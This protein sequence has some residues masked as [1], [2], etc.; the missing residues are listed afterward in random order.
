MTL[1]DFS[2]YVSFRCSLIP[3][4]LIQIG[5]GEAQ[6]LHVQ[7]H[8]Q[9]SKVGVNS[10]CFPHFVLQKWYSH[11]CCHHDYNNGDISISYCFN[12]GYVYGDKKEIKILEAFAIIPVWGALVRQRKLQTWPKTFSDWLQLRMRMVRIVHGSVQDN[13]LTDS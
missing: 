4:N 9:S 5:P 7:S 3:F 12:I 1:P 6:Q 11:Q 13:V 8:R 2:R 10:F